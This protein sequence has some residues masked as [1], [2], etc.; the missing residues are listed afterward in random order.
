MDRFHSRSHGLGIRLGPAKAAG[1]PLKKLIDLPAF[2]RAFDE[3][4]LRLVR[5]WIGGI[6][7]VCGHGNLIADIVGEFVH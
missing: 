5:F 3:L 7:R 6:R 1:Q 4:P 2:N